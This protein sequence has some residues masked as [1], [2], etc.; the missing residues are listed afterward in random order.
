MNARFTLQWAAALLMLSTLGCASQPEW[1]GPEQQ[2]AA[3]TGIDDAIQIQTQA[4]AA[5]LPGDLGSELSLVTALREALVHSPALQS[6]LWRVRQAQAQ[7]HQ[8]RLLPNPVLS[9]MI[10][11]PEAGGSPMVE[12]GLAAELLSLLKWPDRINVADHQLQAASSQVLVTALDVLSQTQEAYARAQSLQ[13]ILPILDQRLQLTQ[14]MVSLAQS[15]LEAGEGTRVDLTT[16]QAQVAELRLELLEQKLSRDQAMLALARLLGRPSAQTDWTL[17]SWQLPEVGTATEQDWLHAAMEQRP[18]LQAARW[19]LKAL[20][21]E[22]KLS[23]W[24]WL[25][26]NDAGVSAE[27]EAGSGDWGVGPAAAIALPIFDWGQAQK[28]LATARRTEAEHLYTQLHR[29]VIQEVREAYAAWTS[30]RQVLAELEDQ[31]VPLLVRREEEVLAAYEAGASDALALVLAQNDLQA[32]RAR[33][34]NGR[35]RASQALIRLQRAAGGPGN[36]VMPAAPL[37]QSNHTQEMQP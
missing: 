24:G 10:R 3:L 12:A 16:L 33:L 1:P 26:S 34:V 19:E 2:G 11:W 36:R 13:A 30:S 20:G 28:N 15:R 32:A 14:E 21:A 31:L 25:G 17:E 8:A 27:R 5:D 4:Q 35:E 18:Q 23:Q 6:S 22:V 7:A 37:N 29:Q 9:V